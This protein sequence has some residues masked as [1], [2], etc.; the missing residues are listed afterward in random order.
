MSEFFKPLERF[1][2]RNIANSATC[3]ELCLV[4]TLLGVGI[5]Y[6]CRTRRI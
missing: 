6:T 2:C 5:F 1:H 3:G 4:A